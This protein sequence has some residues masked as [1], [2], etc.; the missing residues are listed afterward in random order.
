MAA[1][2]LKT[3]LFRKTG[4]D[5]PDDFHGTDSDL[6]CWLV[7]GNKFRYASM[8]NLRLYIRRLAHATE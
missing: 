2:G 4:N 3:L 8:S 6:M 7:E 5:W 1:L